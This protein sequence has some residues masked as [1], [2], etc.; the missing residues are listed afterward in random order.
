MRYSQKQI[1]RACLPEDLAA[2]RSL[3]HAR[4]LAISAP[5][6]WR[7]KEG[8]GV[9]VSPKLE[10]K[11]EKQRP[12]GGRC[13]L[14][15]CELLCDLEESNC[16]LCALPTINPFC[17]HL[18][19]SDQTAGG[20]CPK[21]RSHPEGSSKFRA[22]YQRPRSLVG[23]STQ[24]TKATIPTSSQGSFPDGFRSLPSPSGPFL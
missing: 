18:G 16:C 11:F 12:P 9:G 1:H 23:A 17:S 14:F 7:R 20:T 4:D 22:P 24:R 19:G 15:F 3:T 10:P 13:P 6:V 21:S 2:G 8:G 5:Q